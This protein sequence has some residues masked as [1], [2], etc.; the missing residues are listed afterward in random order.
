MRLEK[1]LKKYKLLIALHGL[2]IIYSFGS[3]FGKLA[4][5]EMFFSAPFL[6]Y[7]A[8]VLL[9]MI[10]YALGWQQIIKSLPL[11]VAY[12]NKAV[13]MIWGWIF[14]WAFFGEE[15]SFR[16]LSSIFLIIIGIVIFSLGDKQEGT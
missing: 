1:Y 12:S 13:L 7:Y 14:G 2:L 9:F 16:K 6:G 4:S 10:V 5:G 11:S 15:I 8:M 3:V